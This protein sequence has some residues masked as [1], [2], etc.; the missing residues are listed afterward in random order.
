MPAY[1]RL[2]WK[3]TF[4]NGGQI[5]RACFSELGKAAADEEVQMCRKL[6]GRWRRR[7]A[8]R[9]EN[10]SSFTAPEVMSIYPFS[11]ES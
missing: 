2:Y 6:V 1:I 10:G 4:P 7:I 8:F 9:T 11:T 5:D 3:R